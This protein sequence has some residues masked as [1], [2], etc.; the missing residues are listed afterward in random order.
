METNF[1]GSIE[2]LPE[3]H[4]NIVYSKDKGFYAKLL[5]YGSNV[6]APA[7]KTENVALWK[8][9]S[10]SKV[11]HQFKTKFEEIKKEYLNLIDEFRWNDLIYKSTFNFEPV[12]GD[13][14]HLY[15]GNDG[16]LFLSMIEPN[17]WKRECIGSFILNSER[18]WIK[19]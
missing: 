19:I 1:T 12:I 14:Y 13:V 15:V 4:D 11:N 3:Y 2:D 17:Q 8:G 6:G 18:K 9:V 7:I 10:V 16:N 5:P